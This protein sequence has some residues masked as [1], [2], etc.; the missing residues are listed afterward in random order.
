[1][2][3]VVTKTPKIALCRRCRGAG[4]IVDELGR[5][6]NCPQCN[7]SG[8]GTVRAVVEMDIRPYNP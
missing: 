5:T 3:Q 7:G 4:K 8:R 1:M 2:K 6:T